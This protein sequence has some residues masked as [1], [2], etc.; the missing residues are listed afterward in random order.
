MLVNENGPFDVFLKLRHFSGMKY[1]KYS[2]QYGTTLISGI[3]SCIWCLSIWI[4]V[5]LLL[6][7]LQIENLNLFEVF[8]YWLAISS[9]VIVID[10][11]IDFLKK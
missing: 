7:I 8:L 10:S 6:P 9:G 5:L 11:I 3:L 1:D 4:A 2:N